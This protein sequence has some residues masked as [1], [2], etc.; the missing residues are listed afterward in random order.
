MLLLVITG[1]I[2]ARDK[3]VLPYRILYLNSYHSGFSWTDEVTTGIQN[4]FAQRDSFDLYTEYMDAKR[5]LLADVESWTL[6]LLRKKY[7]PGY[8]DIIIASDNSALD[9]VLK[10]KEDPLFKAIP[11]VFCGISNP[12][13]YPLDEANLYGVYERDMFVAS[14]YIFRQI[15]PNFRTVYFVCD[16]TNT[17]A[18]YRTN[19]QRLLAK[20]PEY[21]LVIVDSVYQSSISQLVSRFDDQGIVYYA[22]VSV[23]GQGKMLDHFEIAREVFENAKIPVFSNYILDIE[24]ATGGYYATGR[25]HG[26]Y[27]GKIAEQ[28]L[29]HQIIKDR[30]L[31]PPLTG[32]YDYNKMKMFNIDVQMLPKGTKVLNRPVDFFEKY[33]ILILANLAFAVFAIGVIIVMARI[34]KMQRRS[35][36]FLEKAMSKAM[37]SDQLKGAFLANVSHEL[38]TPLNAICGFSELVKVECEDET[39]KSYIDVIYSNSEL[40]AGLVNDLLDISLID[41]NSI[42]IH[43]Q[44]VDLVALF[45]ELRQQAETILVV[46]KKKHIKVN[47]KVNE[48]YKNVNADAFRIS[49]VMLNFIGNA[50]KYTD[51]GEITLGF[52]HQTLCDQYLP[53]SEIP[54][55]SLVLYVSDTGIGIEADK[56]H[57]VFERFRMVDSKFVSQHGGVGL[58]LNISKS[59]VE[60]MGGKIFVSSEPDKGSTFGFY[61]PLD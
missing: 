5:N 28:R 13:D 53:A 34:N 3:G 49:Q 14:F 17:G 2:L 42:R 9:F 39:I 6:E 19:A 31:I 41:A 55:A 7:T 35:K 58:G 52:D 59:M 23:D 25:D 30:V 43:K 22:G 16:R 8:F 37:E 47:V 4:Y 57:M 15:Y 11:V 20:Y 33:K 38:R 61:L 44:P 18:V 50:A 46:R 12:D 10:Y 1:N 24:G 27:A 36:E 21:R 32:V 48:L 40:L 56:H 29:K 54:D 45:R 26:T 51:H 60:L